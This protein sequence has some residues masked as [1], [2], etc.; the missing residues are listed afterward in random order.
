LVRL[1][2]RGVPTIFLDRKPPGNLDFPFVGPDNLS[3]ADVAI[4]HLGRLGHT[5]IA[6]LFGVQDDGSPQQERLAGYHAALESRGLIYDERLV[7]Y[8]SE[9]ETGIDAAKRLLDLP[10]ECVPTAIF[11]ST[12]YLALNVVDAV[13]LRR[14]AGRDDIVIPRT[15]SVIGFDSVPALDSARPRIARVYYNTSLLGQRAIAKLVALRDDPDDPHARGDT[16]IDAFKITDAESVAR[17]GER[18]EPTRPV[19][20]RVSL[21]RPARATGSRRS[22]RPER[23]TA[24][25]TPVIAAASRRSREER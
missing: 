14:A 24:R 23:N 21:R 7:S 8:P 10:S 13:R 18:S 17:P 12:P 1:R 6:G 16:L 11:C 5:R 22:A 20:N 25:D 2:E 3:A 19:A 9:D 4:R 15:L